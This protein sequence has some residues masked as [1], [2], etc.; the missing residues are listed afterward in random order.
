MGTVEANL[1]Y[2]QYPPTN[3]TVRNMPAMKLTYFNLRA[4]AEPARLI[5]AQAGVSYEDNRLPAPWDDMAPWTALKPN[6]PF[7]QLP[8]LCVDG[9]EFS[10]SMTIARYLANEHGLAGKN[11]LD[12]GLMDEIVDALSDATEKQYNAY[13]FEKDEKKKEELQAAFKDTVLP[14]LLK[15]TEKILVSRGG[16]YL[17]GGALSWA[18]I[19]LY[20]F[21]SEIPDKSATEAFSKVHALVAKVGDLPNIKKWVESRPVTTV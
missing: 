12:N 7:G 13:L 4:R 10:Q 15:S 19:M 2:E 16:D 8:T 3:Y 1:C 14:A 9:Q 17:V 6:T 18:D 21:C 20:N 11:A 5:L